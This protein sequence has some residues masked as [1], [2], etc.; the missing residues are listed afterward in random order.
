[1]R[2]IAMAVLILGSVGCAPTVPFRL[3]A[4]EFATG[5]RDDGMEPE[6]FGGTSR[7]RAGIDIGV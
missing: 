2:A 1:M 4:A 6:R 5:E 3:R 7:L